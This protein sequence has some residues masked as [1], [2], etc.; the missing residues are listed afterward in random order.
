MAGESIVRL[1]KLCKET[2]AQLGYVRLLERQRL[3]RIFSNI[4]ER[5]GSSR[6]SDFDKVMLAY[7]GFIGGVALTSL[8]PHTSTNLQVI[9]GSLAFWSGAACYLYK[10][11][12]MT[13]LSPQNRDP[14]QRPIA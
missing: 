1:M 9:F 11:K 2:L 3:L 13:V 4:Q 10:R 12:K 8:A 5:F 14:S 6:L 7:S